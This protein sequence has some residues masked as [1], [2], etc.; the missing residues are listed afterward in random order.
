M[1]AEDGYTILLSTHNPDHALYFATDILALHRPGVYSAGAA[2]DVLTEAL[3][4]EIYSLPVTIA[5]VET[6]RGA[7]KSC[8]PRL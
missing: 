3:I 6:P 5:E 7:V 1:L 4:E 2:E 8:V